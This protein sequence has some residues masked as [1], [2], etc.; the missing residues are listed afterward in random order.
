MKTFFPFSNM[1]AGDNVKGLFRNS[2]VNMVVMSFYS[3]F[4][5]YRKEYKYFV[6]AIFITL[7]TFYMS[8]LLLF[9]GVVLAYVFFNL[10]INRKLKVLGVLLLILLLFI[11]ISPKNVKYVQ[12]ILNDKIS[13]KTDPPR[14][15]VSF[16]QTLDHWVSSSRNFI[17]GSGGGKFSSR[18]SFIT[19]GEYVGWFPQ[20]LTYLSPDFEGNHFQ[21]WNSKILSIPYKDGTSNQPFSFYNKI[22]GE[23]GLIGILLFLIYLS[24]PLKYYKHLSYGRVIFLLIFAYFLLDYW[25]EYFSVIVFFE[26]FIFLDIKKHLQNTTINE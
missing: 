24:I 8:G 5:I 7:L 14:K 20:K 4:F 9:T 16:D 10:S 15:L 21:L 13:S 6:L 2:S 25:F 17:Y 1:S 23:Y 12:K 18:T 11:L 3:I 19:G 22:V 26:L